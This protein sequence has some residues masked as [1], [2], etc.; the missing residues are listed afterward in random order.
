MD[1]VV[2]SGT[3]ADAAGGG[4]ER[5]L[6]VTPAGADPQPGTVDAALEAG[7][8]GERAALGQAGVTVHVVASRRRGEGGDGRAAVRDRRRRRRGAP[9]TRNRVGRSGSDQAFT[10]GVGGGRGA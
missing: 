10:R 7:L 2:A 5:V 9:R 1:A 4:I 3:N 8:A 6:V